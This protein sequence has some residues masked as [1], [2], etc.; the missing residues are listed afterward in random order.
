MSHIAKAIAAMQA[1]GLVCV[2]ERRN[3]SLNSSYATLADVWELLRPHLSQHGLAVQFRHG[4]IREIGSQIIQ[5][6]T[7]RMTH[8][9]SGETEEWSGEYPMPEGNR[10][11]NFAQRFGSATT[12]AQRYALCAAFGVVTGDDDDAR[13]AAS[14]VGRAAGATI[15]ADPKNWPALMDGAW[16]DAPT[17]AGDGTLGDIDHRARVALWKAHPDHAGLLAYVADW[18]TGRLEQSGTSWSQW[19]TEA[20][21]TWPDGIDQC[22]PDELRAAARAIFAASKQ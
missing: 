19:T 12:Y 17:P 4:S 8:A 9:E 6:M 21:G 1:S 11:V 14:Q 15:S 3:A 18:I 13:R 7:V 2:K 16:A 10:G 20:G 22:S 5:A